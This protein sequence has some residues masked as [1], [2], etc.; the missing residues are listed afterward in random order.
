VA[1]GRSPSVSAYVSRALEEQA[2]LDDLASMLE[3]MLAES[4]GPLNASERK[5]ADQALGR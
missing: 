1:E 5:A 3:E 2:K 4:G